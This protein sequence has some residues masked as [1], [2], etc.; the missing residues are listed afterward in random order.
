MAGRDGAV[1]TLR[2]CAPNLSKVAKVLCD[3][4]YSGENFANAVK[5]L[6]G[7]EGEVVKRGEL[8]T[9]AVLP[10]RRVVERTFGWLAV[11]CTWW[12]FCA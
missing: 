2:G 5:T 8:H 9:F 10:N 6:I 12:I 11:C 3:S 7:A 1:K 4:G